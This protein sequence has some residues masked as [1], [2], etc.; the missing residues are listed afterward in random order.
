MDIYV[1]ASYTLKMPAKPGN[2][3]ARLHGGTKTLPDGR[4]LK[5]PTYHSWA[6]ANDRCTNPRHKW[7][8]AY[9]GRGIVV[10][11][12]WRRG[13]DNPQAFA[14]FLA[15]LG[16]RPSK[17]LTLDRLDVNGPYA[18]EWNGKKQCKWATKS[19]QRINVRPAEELPPPEAVPAMEV[20]Y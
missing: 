15:D 8:N 11:E 12:R 3:N 17:E 2:S 20:P 9:G 7:Y 16:E 6:A 4:V 18:P 19:E 5:T 1:D 10:C 14:N 13:R